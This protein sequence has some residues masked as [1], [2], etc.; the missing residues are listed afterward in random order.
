MVVVVVYA[1]IL[2]LIK[3]NQT[4]KDVIKAEQ[5]AVAN[6][7]QQACYNAQVLNLLSNIAN[8]SCNK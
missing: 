4:K 5:T 8:C 3:S 1:A 7:L 6:A 2:L